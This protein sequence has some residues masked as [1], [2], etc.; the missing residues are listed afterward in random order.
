[1]NKL[2]EAPGQTL[3]L[4]AAVSSQSMAF[5]CLPFACRGDCYWMCIGADVRKAGHVVGK[6]M[7][8]IRD[9]T[10]ILD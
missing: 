8:T 2:T 6:Q 3:L 7:A 10:L 5:Q 4:P 1:M 9:F